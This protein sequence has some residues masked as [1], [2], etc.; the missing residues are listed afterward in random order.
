VNHTGSLEETGIFRHW[1]RNSRLIFKKKFE[2]EG[3]DP[4]ESTQGY[5]THEK[6]A[7]LLRKKI[8]KSRIISRS[9]VALEFGGKCQENQSNGDT[10]QAVI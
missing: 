3:E 4:T 6:Q 7:L 5:I 10:F 9:D 2:I 8:F 1:T